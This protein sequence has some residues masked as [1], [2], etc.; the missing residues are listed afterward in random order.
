MN[1]FSLLPVYDSSSALQHSA[2]QPR[3]L[4]VSDELGLFRAPEQA[5]LLGNAVGPK[6]VS[7]IP[8]RKQQCGF[9]CAL[10]PVA[11]GAECV[12]LVSWQRKSCLPPDGPRPDFSWYIQYKAELR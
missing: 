4:C 2:I 10:T 6:V 5:V 11:F 1:G 9:T 7:Q 8:V 3:P 12:W